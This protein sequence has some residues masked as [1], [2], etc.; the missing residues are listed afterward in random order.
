MQ[1][2]RPPIRPRKS[3]ARSFPAGLGLIDASSAASASTPTSPLRDSSFSLPGSYPGAGPRKSSTSSEASTVL[4]QVGLATAS[5]SLS[6]PRSPSIDAS[7]KLSHRRAQISAIPTGTP[8][9]RRVSKSGNGT[10]GSLKVQITPSPSATRPE[11]FGVKMDA[12]DGGNTYFGQEDYATLASQSG[13]DRRSSIPITPPLRIVPRKKSPSHLPLEAVTSPAPIKKAFENGHVR[14][15]TASTPP[16]TPPYLTHSVY[17]DSLGDTES[18]RS[19][20]HHTSWPRASVARK[21]DFDEH[22]LPEIPVE[23]VLASSPSAGDVTPKLPVIKAADDQLPTALACPIEQ[24]PDLPGLIR[25]ESGVSSTGSEADDDEES[26]NEFSL[27]DF[28]VPS[29]VIGSPLPPSAVHASPM[30]ST[31]GV[32]VDTITTVESTPRP[33]LFKLESAKSASMSW[34]LAEEV[35][36]DNIRF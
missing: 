15:S 26:D 35:S 21:L 23:H 1:V 25:R 16:S 4:L 33:D 27:E 6:K 5:A 17:S 30:P 19:S 18:A 3:S 2:E 9:I 36:A 22:P 32:A 14:A 29:S 13:E 7:P 28:P 12:L 10:S 8:E 31:H 11:S 34:S 20:L 24:E